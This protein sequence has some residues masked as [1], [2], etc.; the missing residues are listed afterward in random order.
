MSSKSVS[1]SEWETGTFA[2]LSFSSERNRKLAQ[3]LSQR[4]IVKITELRKGIQIDCN[5]HIGQVDFGDFTLQINPKLDGLPLLRLLTYAYGLRDLKLYDRALYQVGL[6]GWFDW[7]IYAFL[8][9]INALCCRGLAKGYQAH[10]DKLTAIRGRIDFGRIAGD[11]GLVLNSLLCRYYQ[12]EEDTLLNRTL[13]AGLLLA[14]KIAIDLNLKYALL[15]TVKILQESIA[16]AE[17][18]SQMLTRA[19][20]ALNRLTD[21]YKPILK[22]IEIL[23]RSQAPLLD[24]DD[25]SITLPGFFFDM[26]FFFEAL[27]SKLLKLLPKEITILDQYRLKYLLAYI[28]R[29]NLQKRPNPTPRP[30]FAFI[31]N[32][33]VIRLL[34]AKYRDLWENPLPRHMLYQLAIYA[35]S[36]LGEQRR[37]TIIYPALSDKPEIQMVNIFDAATGSSQGFVEM[38]PINL[39]KISDILAEGNDSILAEYIKTAI[40]TEH[41]LSA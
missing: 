24:N 30:D 31:K 27:L 36:G 39:Q 32:K 22:I 29:Y 18:D 26:N 17:L 38:V 33:R 25:L 40:L 1:L 4:R 35:L 8:A 19:Y 12:R 2:E 7:L 11:G 23:Y 9:Q 15:K 3:K 20:L 28:P 13:L 10:A 41:S 6:T 21:D 16:T 37:A 34:D 5:S 14:H